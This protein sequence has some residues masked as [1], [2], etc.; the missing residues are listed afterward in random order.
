M[1]QRIRES[2]TVILEKSRI[3]ASNLGFVE[4][5]KEKRQRRCKTFHD[6]DRRN[7]YNHSNEEDR[8]QVEVF[9]AALDKLIEEIRRRSQKAEEINRMFSF[10]WNQN[11]DDT[12]SDV[13]KA[14]E[15]SKF[16]SNDLNAD[17][18]FEEICHL[19]S[20][21]TELF[22]NVSSLHLLNLIHKGTPE[23]FPSNVYCL[24]N[25]ITMPVS[26]AKG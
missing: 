20:V 5:F 1:N 14:V 7:V 10:I 24:E 16:Y 22:G 19:A 6:E 11:T 21:G 18:F 25:F 8:F 2:W 26:V 15:L 9:F 12:D 13:S 17:D 23:Y 4:S 3:V